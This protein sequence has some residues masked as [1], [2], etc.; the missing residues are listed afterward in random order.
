MSA[1]NNN[2]RDLKDW[3]ALFGV[4]ISGAGL[5]WT[6][7]SHFIPISEF[8]RN[9]ATR[10]AGTTIA[11]ANGAGGVAIMNGGQVTTNVITL[12]DR[13]AHEIPPRP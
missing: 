5:V 10:S 8:S 3:L 2:Q 12:E 7:I 4:M 9:P 6:I 11:T 1:G 13:P